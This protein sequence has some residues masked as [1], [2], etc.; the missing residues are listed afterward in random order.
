MG[1]S[2]LYVVGLHHFAGTACLGKDGDKGVFDVHQIFSASEFILTGGT[3]QYS[4]QHPQKLCN[5]TRA[6]KGCLRFAMNI[7]RYRALQ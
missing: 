5:T 7:F 1:N 2:S 4:A 3:T 6:L